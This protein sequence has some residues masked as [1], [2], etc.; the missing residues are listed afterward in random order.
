MTAWAHG[1]LFF[2]PITG[3]RMNE[4]SEKCFEGADSFIG[5]FMLS[6]ESQVSTGYG[7]HYPTE[8]CSEAIFLLIAQLIT[9]VLL[10]GCMIGIFYAKLIK[11]PVK[12]IDGKF[13]KS[14]VVGLLRLFFQ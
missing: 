2:D 1:D 11:P 4:D 10:D 6:M 7:E 14:A 3:E 12:P 5:A 13:S 9:G 8:Q